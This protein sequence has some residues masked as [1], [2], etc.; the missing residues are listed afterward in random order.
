MA[1]TRSTDLRENF[2]EG[3]E[4]GRARDKAASLVGVSGRSVDDAEEAKRRQGE[5]TDIQANFPGS[6]D[7]GQARDTRLPPQEQPRIQVSAQ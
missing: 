6:E 5:R 1:G 2:P 3:S 4:T 7:Y